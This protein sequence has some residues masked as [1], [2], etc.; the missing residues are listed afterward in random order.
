MVDVKSWAVEGAEAP[1]TV[2]SQRWKG[3]DC[4]AEYTTAHQCLLRAR[5]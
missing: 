2:G 5:T 3:E 4:F 1:R